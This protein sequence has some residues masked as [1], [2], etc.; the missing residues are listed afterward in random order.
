MVKKSTP[1]A[2]APPEPGAGSERLQ[3]ILAQSNDVTR[4]NELCGL[5][6][7]GRSF[8]FEEKGGWVVE[9]TCGLGETFRIESFSFP[10]RTK[11]GNKLGTGAAAALAVHELLPRAEQA[12][13]QPPKPLEELLEDCAA[14][15]ALPA[16]A[17]SW[18]RFWKRL[19]GK[20]GPQRAVGM[21][22]AGNDGSGL[23]VLVEAT[24]DGL[25]LMELP[26]S[27]EP[28]ALSEDMS[29]LLA[30]TSITKV[31][32]DTAAQRDIRSLGLTGE[33][34]DVVNLEQVAARLL[35]VSTAPRGLAK[36][37][38]LA[39]GA[40]VQAVDPGVWAEFEGAGA[41]TKD[42]S[43]FS[44]AALQRA[45]LEAQGVLK[46]WQALRAW[47][48]ENGGE[49]SAPVVVEKPG[50]GA[51]GAVA[52]TTAKA[53]EAAKAKA[54]S[55]AEAAEQRALDAEKREQAKAKAKAKAEAKLKGKAKADAKD[56]AGSSLPEDPELASLDEEIAALEQQLRAEGR[57]V[58]P[59]DLRKKPKWLGWQRALDEEL[60]EAGGRLPWPA[61]RERLVAR[62]LTCRLGP[63]L[64]EDK[65]RLQAVA[66]IP[67]SYLSTSD[68]IVTLVADAEGSQPN[69]TKEGSS[70]RKGGKATAQGRSKGAA[71]GATESHSG[72]KKEKR[73][74][75]QL[76]SAAPSV[77]PWKKKAKWSAKEEQAKGSAKSPN[78]GE[79]RKRKDW[80][81]GTRAG[82]G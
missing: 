34:P 43:Q 3:R 11:K 52:S 28:A 9:V 22:T 1:G 40:R 71:A 74:A 27:R 20:K 10:P 68:D 81:K 36:L 32:C 57:D 70:G 56:S 13:A 25:V 64:R 38:G 82:H 63:G 5:L 80:S 79:P 54:A 14:A 30:D 12:L 26:R 75:D 46:T 48:E 69:G 44:D 53:A 51:E 58:T 49:A 59:E 61:L 15:E 29:K 7:W 77:E 73:K 24:V 21:S 4:L 62:R 41:G 17:A 50:K 78:A 31:F 66:C 2:S 72:W 42:L 67:D 76:R 39:L 37:A 18:A 19:R 47:E 23:P 16:E 55:A 35:G 60:R 6:G 33:T 45:A 65:L 8:A